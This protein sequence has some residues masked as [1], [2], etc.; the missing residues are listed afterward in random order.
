MDRPVGQRDSELTS[1]IPSLVIRHATALYPCAERGEAPLVD[2]WVA[3]SGRQIIGVGAEPCPVAGAGVEVDGRGKVVLPGLV[4][5]HHHFFQSLTRAVP[6]GQREFS[7]GWLRSMYPL[8]QELNDEAMHAAAR[9]AAAELVLTG[10]TTSVDFA[11]LYPDG[12]A[13]LLDA[14]VSAVREV[15]LRLHVVRGCTPVLENEI[16]RE[17]LRVP[18]TE[19]IALVESRAAILAACEAAVTKFH[20]PSPYAMCRVAFGPTAVPYH[21]PDLLRGLVELSERAGCGRHVHLQPR[22]DEV[23]RC[24]KAHGCRPDEFLRRV[25]WLGPGSWLAHATMHTEEDIRVLADTGT[26]V[27]HCPSQNMRLGFPAG[28]IPAMRAAGVHVGV[29]VDGAASND[30]GSMLS[31]LRLVLLMHRLAGVQPD[32]PPAKWMSPHDVLWMATRD[33]AAVLGRDDIGRL[34]PGCAADVILV[35]LKQ[36]GYAGGLHDPLGTLLMTGDS[37]IVDTT[38][39]DGQI[40]VKGGRLTRVSEGRVIDDANRMS[41]AMVERAHRRTGADFGSVAVRLQALTGAGANAG[42]TA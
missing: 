39:V 33:G 22:P 17:L 28:P 29:G 10:A 12:N 1:P 41:A 34:G 2:A 27:A 38:I 21:D 32:Y 8:W 16:E 9:V 19:R 15:G 14:E 36:V 35:N 42:D 6:L 7:L 25:G 11:Y 13:G 37:S 18:G 26:G 31:E 24:Q 30:G 5:V 3:I 4:N 40:V 23:T 20:D